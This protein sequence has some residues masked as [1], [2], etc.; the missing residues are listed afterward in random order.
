MTT[1]SKDS[2]QFPTVS[3]QMNSFGASSVVIS[4]ITG[5]LL[6]TLMGARA[7]AEALTQAGVASEELFRG[8]RLPN[9]P[10]VPAPADEPVDQTGHE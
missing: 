4:L 10:N 1:A 6:V 7:L 2:Q 5:P 9:L 8:D 3:R